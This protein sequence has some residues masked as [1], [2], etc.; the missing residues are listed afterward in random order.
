MAQISIND[1]DLPTQLM[2]WMIL[3]YL[4]IFVDTSVVGQLHSLCCPQNGLLS[5]L[6]PGS[7]QR[8]A[9]LK[10]NLG[11]FFNMSLIDMD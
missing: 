2:F 11:F 6:S 9:P 10:L 8:E 5:S 3:M 4:F 1:K 7:H